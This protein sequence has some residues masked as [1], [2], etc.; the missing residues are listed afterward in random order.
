MQRTQAMPPGVEDSCGSSNH[1]LVTY[2]RRFHQKHSGC[3]EGQ[4]AC[5]IPEL[6]KADPNWFGISI[7]TVDGQC[8][9]VGET[10]QPFTIQSISKP[11]VYGLALQ[12]EGVNR[13]LAKV[14]VEPSGD[15]FNSISLYADTGRPFNP[16]INAGAIA[17]TGLVHGA[18][19]GEKMRRILDFFSAFAGRELQVDEAVYRSER[20]TGF[21]NFAIGYML[22][23]FGILESQPEPVLDLYFRQCSILVTCRD[24]ALMAATLA[25]GGLNPVSGQVAVD[26][27]LVP[28]ILSVMASCGMYDYSGEWIYRVGMP[29]KSGVGGGII[30]VLPGHMGIAVFSPL[31]DPRGNSVRGIKVF[32]DLSADLELHL[33][34]ASRS[35]KSVVRRRY[36]AAQV[37]SKRFRPQAEQ[38]AL[39][40]LGQRV[41][42]YDLQGELTLFSMDRV[43]RDILALPREVDYLIIDVRRV[44]DAERPA[45]K[46]LLDFAEANAPRYRELILSG[47]ESLASILDELRGGKADSPWRLFGE[48]DAAIEYCENQ[49]LD[50]SR[51]GQGST[52]DQVE[53][54]DFDL[55]QG[56]DP[57]RIEVLRCL[58]EPRCYE[59]G[60]W[61][62]R[63]GDTADALFFLT[64]GRVSISVDL[65]D[66]ASKR[67][68][69]CAPGMLFGEM[70]LLER[71]PRSANVRAD[72]PVTCYALPLENFQRLTTSHPDL[73]VQ[74]LE[75]F[76]KSLSLRVRKLT[77]EVRTLG[78]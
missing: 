21:R 49:L 69:T 15:A 77:D 37:S 31:L 1:P 20:E 54:N 78:Q 52:P 46:L 45:L 76:A 70:A 67:L 5:Y 34:Q 33:Y 73:K 10:R 51:T 26:G 30:G 25:N 3:L 65:P 7:A 63:T 35:L 62:I 47:A 16:M 29:S 57:E 44:V 60:Q 2:L 55:C 28:R 53:L 32:S 41:T 61:I 66:G 14:G 48:T 42:I 4:L 71:R 43:I 24:L 27:R 19:A 22:R 64:S 36:D 72:E 6:T 38:Q 58:L 18:D 11:F 56:M 68:G 8:Y 17:S 59:A 23:N 75:N 40:Q 50:E 74:L 39:A 13:V 12:D 9:E